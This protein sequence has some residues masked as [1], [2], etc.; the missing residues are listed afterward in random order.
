MIPEPLARMLHAARVRDPED[1]EHDHP[2]GEPGQI[3]IG[4]HADP[5]GHLPHLSPPEVFD[6][7]TADGAAEKQ[8]DD[9]RDDHCGN[10]YLRISAAGGELSEGHSTL[11]RT[12]NRGWLK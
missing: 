2:R 8:D 6:H 1:G 4:R 10:T 12:L 9:R 5:R 7:P 3:A 11:K